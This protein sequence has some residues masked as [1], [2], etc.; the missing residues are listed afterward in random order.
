MV[1]QNMV[2]QKVH[3]TLFCVF[4][5]EYTCKELRGNVLNIHFLR[6][7]VFESRGICKVKSKYS[8]T[9]YKVT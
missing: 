3:S 2:V 5:A 4:G 1:R 8:K 9:L 7:N 6:E